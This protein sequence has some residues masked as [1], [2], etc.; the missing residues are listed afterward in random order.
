MRAVLRNAVIALIAIAAPALVAEM[1]HGQAASPAA[2]PAPTLSA[3]VPLMIGDK[4][5]I[6][7]YETIDI[8]A[9]K[10][11]S[12]DG[13][14]PQAPLRTFY[15]RMDVSGDYTVEQDGAI[16]IPL[17]GRFQIEGRALDDV[18]SEVA[19]SFT[20]TTGRAANIDIK[21]AD[22][23]PVYVVGPVKNPGAYKYV[24]GMIVLHA[25]ALAGGVDRG[26]QNLSGMIEG[27]RQVERLR[28]VTVEVQQLLARRARLL[29][30]RDGETV[31]PMPAQLATMA[32][33]VVATNFLATETIILRA[34]K[35]KRQQEQKEVGLKIAAAQSEVDALNRKLDQADVQR[36]LRTERLDDMQKLKDRG[37]VTNNNVLMLRSELSDIEAHRQDYLVAFVQAKAR[38][39]EIEGTGVR[40]A[41]ERAVNLATA[42]AS[43]EKELAV[44]REAMISAGSIASILDRPASRSQDAESYQIVRQSKDG[45]TT[46]AATET[47]ALMPGDVLKISM[48]SSVSK[49]IPVV[50]LPLPEPRLPDTQTAEKSLIS[51][52]VD[53]FGGARPLSPKLITNS[54]HTNIADGV[55]SISPRP[56]AQGRCKRFEL[57]ADHFRS[58]H[59]NGS[60]LQRSSTSRTASR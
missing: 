29:A 15:Q 50:P 44:A 40:L 48:K 13:A 17:L 46:H 58:L 37:L 35:F 45:A 9:A 1:A 21:I 6:S 30:E 49:P 39:A 25:I 22:R 24:P 8:G 3:R 36:A 18:R 52:P 7:F 42:I 32:G 16:S 33:E 41:S 14:A 56:R 59:Y 53:S 31:L 19:L 55:G 5:K 11:G 12:S 43:A 60:K 51:W 26:E 27:A 23:S 38:L 47:S 10:H 2:E 34:E 54:S 28:S 20:S 57:I 4:L